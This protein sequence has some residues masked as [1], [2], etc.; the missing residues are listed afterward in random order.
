M[1]IGFKGKLKLS[2]P[3]NSNFKRLKKHI[4]PFKQK[5]LNFARAKFAPRNF[6]KFSVFPPP[7]QVSVLTFWLF[8]GAFVTFSDSRAKADVPPDHFNGFKLPPFL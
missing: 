5:C 1:R 8:L 6:L 3:Q 2:S 4:T 7:V